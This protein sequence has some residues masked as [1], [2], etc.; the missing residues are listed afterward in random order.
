MPQYA[1]LL[2]IVY[3]MGFVLVFD[4]MH[5]RHKHVWESWSP[6]LMS[7]AESERLLKILEASQDF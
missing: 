1:A 2:S 7:Q 4:K 6:N 3:M 5:W